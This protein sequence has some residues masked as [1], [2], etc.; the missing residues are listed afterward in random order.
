MKFDGRGFGRWVS[1]N[2]YDSAWRH[3]LLENLTVGRAIRGLNGKLSF[4][5]S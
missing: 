5:L 1:P 2:R 3:G 4:E